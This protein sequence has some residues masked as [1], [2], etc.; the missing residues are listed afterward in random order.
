MPPTTYQLSVSTF[1]QDA[2]PKVLVMLGLVD[3]APVDAIVT[4]AP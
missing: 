1:M 3:I 4:P 2:A